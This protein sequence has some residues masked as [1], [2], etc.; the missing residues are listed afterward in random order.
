MASLTQW[1]WVW[2]DSGSW[3]WT[4]R[5]GVLQF[6]ESQRVGHDWTTELNCTELLVSLYFYCSF[7]LF[8]FFL[9]NFMVGGTFSILFSCSRV[10]E[11]S[12]DRMIKGFFFFF[13]FYI[14]G[15]IN[16][17]YWLPFLS[18]S[19]F[20]YLSFQISKFPLARECVIIFWPWISNC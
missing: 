16:N 1:T 6:M 15:F 11:K 4:G 12:G 10:I 18:V 14:K 17:F 9:H 7:I 3:W 8:Y 13:K 20:E 19:W 2:V 5:P